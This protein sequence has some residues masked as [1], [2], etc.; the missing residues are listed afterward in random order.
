MYLPF[1]HAQ[2]SDEVP[3]KAFGF[4]IGSGFFKANN[5]VANYYNGSERN[6]NKMSYILTNRYRLDEIK[7]A[8]DGKDFALYELSQN[9]RYKLATPVSLKFFLNLTSSRSLFLEIHQIALAAVGVFS[10]EID[11]VTFTS[12]PALRMCNIWGVETRTMLDAGYRWTSE[13][14]YP[15]LQWFHEIGFNMT[16][17]KV[18]DN[19]IQIGSFEES[20]IDRGA[21]IPGQGLYDPLQESVFGIG[22]FG[23]LG[24]ELKLTKNIHVDIGLTARLQD[25]NLGEYKKMH[26]NYGF[27]FRVNVLAF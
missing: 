25:I 22:I 24:L 5:Y 15:L 1:V 2:D 16:N 23:N 14:N 21:Y 11:S 3:F 27:L 17:T 13:T 7:Q 4:S 10:I 20:L 26:V 8:L 19:R 9:M 12:E 6:P 18:K